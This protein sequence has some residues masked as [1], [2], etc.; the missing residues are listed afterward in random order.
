MSNEIAEKSIDS[1]T[2]VITNGLNSQNPMAFITF[3]II[4]VGSLLIGG[5]SAG[6]YYF[7]NKMVDHIEKNNT[8]LQQQI[9]IEKSSHQEIMDK[10]DT[11]ASILAS[12]QGIHFTIKKHHKSYVDPVE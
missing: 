4:S 1:V 8:L 9:D 5:I 10:L 11:I 3:V 2:S 7:Q 6:E 12:K